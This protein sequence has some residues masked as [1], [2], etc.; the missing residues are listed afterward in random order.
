M[1]TRYP[2]SKA[3]CDRRM[4][5]DPTSTGSLNRDGFVKGMWRIDEELRKAQ[6]HKPVA[7]RIQLR[8][9]K[10]SHPPKPILR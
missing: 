1:H 6:M 7:S 4:E 10:P 3:N 9:P 5:C 2:S 8:H